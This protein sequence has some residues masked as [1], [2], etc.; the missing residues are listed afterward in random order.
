MTLFMIFGKNLTRYKDV[1]KFPYSVGFLDTETIRY[2][3]TK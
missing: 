1:P 2:D 3:S